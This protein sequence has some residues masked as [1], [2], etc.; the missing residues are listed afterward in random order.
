MNAMKPKILL[1]KIASYDLEGVERFVRDSLALCASENS[2]FHAGQKVLLKPNRLREKE[3]G[4]VAVDIMVAIK[5]IQLM[6]SA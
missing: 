3:R 4:G 1:R 6:V 2:S 5:T